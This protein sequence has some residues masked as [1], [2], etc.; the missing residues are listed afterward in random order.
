MKNKNHFIP[1]I[2][3]RSSASLKLERCHSLT[4]SLTM[5]RLALSAL[6]PLVVNRFGRSL[7]LC[8]LEFDKEAISAG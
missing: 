3:F 7:R 6:S 8:Y 2:I 4:H 1:L 5:S